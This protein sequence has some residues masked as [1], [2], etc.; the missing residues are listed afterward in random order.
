M[1]HSGPRNGISDH[2]LPE[3]FASVGVVD[4]EA[5]AELK[6]IDL[7]EIP[8][9]H[10]VRRFA[11]IYYSYE[12]QELLLPAEREIITAPAAQDVYEWAK[13]IEPI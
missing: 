2:F 7:S 1:A 4:A 3:S 6:S 12:K 5:C 8:E 11:Q 10:P 9:A 13:H